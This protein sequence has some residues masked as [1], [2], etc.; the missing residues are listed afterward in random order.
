MIQLDQINLIYIEATSHCN[1]HCPQCP[2][3]D[4]EGFVRQDLKPAHLNFDLFSRNF[5][6]SALPNL[7]DI[8]F[9]GDYGDI[10]MHPD[11]GKF[12]E[13]FKDVPRVRIVTNG[14]MRSSKW[15]AKLAKQ[16][17]ILIT[18]SIDGLEDTNKIYRINSKWR[19]I[20][21]N[22]QAYIDAGG[23]AEWKFLVFEHNEHQLEQA[24]KLANDMGFVRFFAQHTNRSWWT[25]SVWP[26][27]IAGQYQ[28]DIKVSTDSREILLREPA[29]ALIRHETHHLT[30]PNCWLDRGE[31]YINHLGH[32][33]PCCMHSGKT[34]QNNLLSRM[35]RKVVGDL[36][37]I[38]VTQTSFADIIN[39]D[40]YQHKLQNSFEKASTIHP[41]CVSHCS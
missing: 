16:K 22:A 10:M 1:L 34:W 8:I 12:F 23:R 26:V 11:C 9:E 7:Q 17:N 2:R 18:F 15:W 21:S 14:S 35:W 40:F 20:M 38:D 28:Y 6:L 13:F 5:D 31:M 24:R 39:G 25:G 19:N 33:L 37:A 3:F 36:S 29:A 4:Q 32:V 41:G 27:K 30:R